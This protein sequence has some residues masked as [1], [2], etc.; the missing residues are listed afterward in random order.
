MGYDIILKF[1]F[2][3]KKE[4]FCASENIMNCVSLKKDLTSDSEVNKMIVIYYLNN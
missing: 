3:N 2:G 4:K 1:L